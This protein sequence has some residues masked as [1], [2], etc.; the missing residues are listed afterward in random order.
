MKGKDISDALGNINET[1]VA[2]SAPK[3]KKK[4][5]KPWIAATAAVLVIAIALG[6]VF[7]RGGRPENISATP[8]ALKAY[9]I[10]TPEYPEN[11]PYPSGE[12]DQ[13]GQKKWSADRIARN[14]YNGAGKDFFDFYARS[15]AAAIGDRQKNSVYS[16]VSLLMALAMLAELTDG[17]TRAQ[18]L[19]AL[20]AKDIGSLRE[21]AHA[22]W[23]ANYCNDGATTS[24]FGSSLWLADAIEYKADTLK[25]LAENYYASSFSGSFAQK[26]YARAIRDWLN[27]QTGDLLQDAANALQFDADT[28]MA[29]FS[30]VC[31][32][33]KWNDA[34]DKSAT[35]PD[36]FHAIS[37]DETAPFMHQNE[38][39]G[40]YYWGERF[41]AVQLYMK[42]GGSMW[43]FLPDEGVT[44]DT[45]AADPE[46]WDI[47]ALTNDW[48]A[49][50]TFANKKYLR[51]DL[52]LPKFDIDSDMDLTETARQ[53]GITDCFDRQRSDFSPLTSDTGIAISQCKQAARVAVD[54]EGVVAT[55]FTA[56]IGAGATMPP[57]DK[58][59]FVLDRPFFFAITGLDALPLFTGT[60]WNLI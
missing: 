47:L 27:A 35:Q 40:T 3:K 46:V 34:F 20:G 13:A 2:E 37:G 4:R 9:A 33:A 16:P 12:L 55:A 42:N 24:V 28:V 5:R 39:H 44:P 10:G 51:I 48:E 56:L 36:M 19:T 50:E 52:S 57:E 17:D 26:K 18:I 15:A 32:R 38:I 31:F 30:T 8:G 54:E 25:T 22:V 14:A 1:Y 53:L 43:F 60:V 29:L 21:K 11:A 58:M 59:E 41:G 49:Q 6:I 7:G 23:N 45:L